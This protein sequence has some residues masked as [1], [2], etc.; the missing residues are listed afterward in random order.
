MLHPALQAY[1]NTGD[2][3]LDAALK[4]SRARLQSPPSS[5]RAHVRPDSPVRAATAA[6]SQVRKPSRKKRSQLNQITQPVQPSSPTRM[7]KSQQQ[8]ARYPSPS[9]RA[10]SQ[11]P[12]PSSP[13][14]SSPRQSSPVMST[15]TIHA[16]HSREGTS[17]QSRSMS[18]QHR[19][20]SLDRGPVGLGPNPTYWQL[21]LPLTEC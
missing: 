3:R 17:A 21:P 13:R 6:A 1:F 10:S 7:V 14:A 16:A 5:F 9:G 20:Q 19:R 2:D 15:Y 12:R 11:S 8:P 4:G 18:P